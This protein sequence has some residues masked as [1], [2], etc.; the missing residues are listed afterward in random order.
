MR[1]RDT[2]TPFRARSAIVEP[3]TQFWPATRGCRTILGVLVDVTS[4]QQAENTVAK[5]VEEPDGRYVCV[6]SVHPVMEAHDDP[7]FRNILNRAD[8][9][10]A[11]GMPLVWA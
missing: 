3:L 6:C 5:W 11:D 1:A 4:Y 7:A 8:L 10:T 2:T 9:V